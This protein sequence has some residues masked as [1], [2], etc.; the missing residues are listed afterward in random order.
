MTS[1]K[2]CFTSMSSMVSAEASVFV[3]QPKRSPSAASPW[4]ASTVPAPTISRSIS[5]ANSGGVRR[6]T[7]SSSIDR[8]R[9][10]SARATHVCVGGCSRFGAVRE[11]RLRVRG[12]LGRHRA[13]SDLA[14]GSSLVP[15]GR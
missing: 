3:T 14:S 5:V 2:P 1:R 12:Q 8:P 15:R 4:T 7:S 6:C 9:P 11:V 13:C 10:A